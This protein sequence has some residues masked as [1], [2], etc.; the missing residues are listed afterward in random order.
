MCNEADVVPDEVNIAVSVVPDEAMAE[1]P[2]VTVSVR[3]PD[4]VDGGGKTTERGKFL[5]T[6]LLRLPPWLW[7]SIASR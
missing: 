7:Q 6:R 2:E 5:S 3:E 4:A 1:V